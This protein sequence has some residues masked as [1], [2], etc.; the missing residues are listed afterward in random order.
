MVVEVVV[1][2]VLCCNGDL[3]WL[4]EPIFEE[5]KRERKQWDVWDTKFGS[6]KVGPWIAFKA[7]NSVS[8]PLLLLA[9]RWWSNTGQSWNQSKILYL[10]P[11]SKQQ[12]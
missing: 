12:K 7:T 11:K 3:L 6:S 10:I 5:E 8:Q 4:F 1:E 2:M 9:G